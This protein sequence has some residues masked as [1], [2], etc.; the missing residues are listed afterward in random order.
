MSTNDAYIDG[1]SQDSAFCLDDP[2]QDRVTGAVKNQALPLT[3]VDPAEMSHPNVAD[4]DNEGDEDTESTHESVDYTSNLPDETLLLIFRHALPPSWVMWSGSSLAPFPQTIWSAAIGTKLCIIGVCKTWHHLGVEFLYENVTLGSLGQ[5]AAFVRT[6]ETR[7]ELAACTRHVEICYLVVRGYT[8]L[9]STESRK[10]FELCPR[11]THFVFTSHRIHGGHRSP[12]SRPA[13]P[14][15]AGLCLAL[16]N[17][18]IGDEVPYPLVLPA[19]VE[20]CHTLQSLSLLLPENFGHAHPKL[21]FPCLENFN[22]AIMCDSPVPAAYWVCPALRAGSR[23]CEY[24][25]SVIDRD[26]PDEYDLPLGPWLTVLWGEASPEEGS[27][28]DSDYVYASDEEWFSE[29]DSEEHPDQNWEYYSDGER[30]HS[31]ASGATSEDEFHYEVEREEVTIF[32][33]ILLRALPEEE[34]SDDEVERDGSDNQ[35]G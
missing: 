26:T 1:Q 14:A 15:I 12:A 6:L 31:P 18:D 4:A 2:L 11:L 21:T 7:L 25:V 22:V 29:D 13:F 24:G 5:L 35:Q 8:I 16:T 27:S 33:N 32:E 3:A 20:L 9:H 17:L 10:I 34:D 28:D 30:K 19:L 23:R